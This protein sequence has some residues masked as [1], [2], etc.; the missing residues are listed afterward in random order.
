MCFCVLLL[1]FLVC[2][3]SK[4]LHPQLL[5]LSIFL[6]E[7]IDSKKKK[8]RRDKFEDKKKKKCET[9]VFSN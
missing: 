8:R 4:G 5:N 3:F 7:K 1:F 9:N 2:V 6:E